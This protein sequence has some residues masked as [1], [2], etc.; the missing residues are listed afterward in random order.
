MSKPCL[1]E[2]AA[3][4]ENHFRARFIAGKAAAASE[5][6]I[7]ELLA[8]VIVEYLEK[9][10]ALTAAL[11]LAR[12]LNLRWGVERIVDGLLDDILD[13]LCGRVLAGFLAP[14]S[15]ASSPLPARERHR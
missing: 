14:E 4:L 12:P 8:E 3:D 2:A 7:L 1:A 11:E 5:L 10:A 15:L 6:A 13:P 9:M